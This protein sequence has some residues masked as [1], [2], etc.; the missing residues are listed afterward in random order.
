MSKF[1]KIEVN[2]G[3]VYIRKEDVGSVIHLQ[4]PGKELWQVFVDGIQIREAEQ[5]QDVLDFV[6]ELLKE[7]DV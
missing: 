3:V 6:E 1:K 5:Q 7:F 4:V 2:N